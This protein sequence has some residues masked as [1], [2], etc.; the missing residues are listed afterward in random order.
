MNIRINK[1]EL[2]DG[3]TYTFK[4]GWGDTFNSPVTKSVSFYCTQDDF[5]VVVNGVVS[6]FNTYSSARKFLSLSV[7]W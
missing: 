7:N 1:K 5:V 2:F 4:N 3:C 6:S